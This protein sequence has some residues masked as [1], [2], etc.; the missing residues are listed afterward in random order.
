MSDLA[1]LAILQVVVP[2]LGAPVCALIHHRG[3]VHWLTLGAVPDARW[4]TAATM[5]SMPSMKTLASINS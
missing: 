2:L 5:A 4:S 3:V 1:D